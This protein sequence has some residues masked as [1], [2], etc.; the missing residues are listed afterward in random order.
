VW[1]SLV[2]GLADVDQQTPLV[3]MEE[4]PSELISPPLSALLQVI[5]DVAVVVTVGAVDDAIQ[6]GKPAD[7]A[8]MRVLFNP[9][10]LMIWRSPDSR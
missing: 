2:V 1:L 6:S 10:A 8:R 3:V 4:P 9:S 5:E 7:P